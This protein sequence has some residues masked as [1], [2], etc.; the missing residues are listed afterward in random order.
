MRMIVADI[1]WN[2]ISPGVAVTMSAGVAT[3]RPGETPENLLL[4]ADVALYRAK[5]RGRNR[6]ERA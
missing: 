5:D 1:D 3:L 4:R 6:I 2:S